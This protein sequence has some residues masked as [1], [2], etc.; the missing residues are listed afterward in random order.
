MKKNIHISLTH[1]LSVIILFL[2]IS[3]KFSNLINESQNNLYEV[4]IKFGLKIEIPLFVIVPLGSSLIFLILSEFIFKR[5]EEDKKI[6]TIYIYYAALNGLPLLASLTLLQ[7][8]NLPR[9]ILLPYLLLAP[10]LYVLIEYIS[11]NKKVLIGLLTFGTAISF[12]Y[13]EK[14]LSNDIDNMADAEYI[15]ESLID[16]TYVEKTNNNITFSEAIQLSKKIA[17]TDRL[18]FDKYKIDL[19]SLCCKQFAYNAYNYK[20][21]GYIDIYKDNLI[22]A[23]NAGNIVSIDLSS[24]TK[25][26][27]DHSY[28]II[29]SNIKEIIKNKNVF[30]NNQVFSPDN[31]S[32]ESIRDILIYN[33]NIYLSFYQEK[34]K[35]CLNIEIISAPMSLEFLNFENFF[36]YDECIS[37][38]ESFEIMG[39]GGRI[40]TDGESIYFTIGWGGD[41]F[42]TTNE[43]S[44]FGKIFQINIQTKEEKILSKGHKNPQGLFYIEKI[45]SLIF[46]EHGPISGDEINLLDLNSNGI[47]N[48]GWPYSTYGIHYVE[49]LPDNLIDFDVN[50]KN[51]EDFGYVEPIYYFHPSKIYKHGISEI[52][53]NSFS[54]DSFFIGT[55]KG[56]VLYDMTLNKE[57][58]EAV[59]LNGYRMPDRIR[60][61]AHDKE[62]NRYFI[63]F[64]SGPSLGVLEEN[65]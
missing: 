7:F 52:I 21:G 13:T 56:L 25:N 8:H 58:N 51:H 41:F 59:A 26:D 60:D 4:F 20:P 50:Q 47:K 18:V 28:K 11:F 23:N 12:I 15:D 49:S 61:L 1:L 19:F 14:N 5:L 35:D 64:D 33:E 44:Y 53:G 54:E 30:I 63:L 62:N 2:T 37:K 46:T 42:K 9:S 43:D 29:Q 24:F 65:K 31:F 3:Y 34:T 22:F 38:S 16:I 39:F 57:L 36:T 32:A 48:Y 10:L 40:V 6:F 27:S 17:W 55:M 45:N